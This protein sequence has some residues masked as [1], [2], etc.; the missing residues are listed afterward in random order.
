M[1]HDDLSSTK[2]CNWTS[3]TYTTAEADDG[4]RQYMDNQP[5]VMTE[6]VHSSSTSPLAIPEILTRVGYFLPLWVPDGHGNYD[7]KPRTIV[8]CMLVSKQWYD[9]LVPI[10][11]HTCLSARITATPP[12]VLGRFLP[13]IRILQTNMFFPLVAFQCNR[14]VELSILMRTLPCD[15]HGDGGDDKTRS[16]SLNRYKTLV[17]SNPRLKSLL[18]NGLLFSDKSALD[19][20][21]LAGL[22]RLE[23][24]TLKCWDG[25]GGRLASALGAVARTLT[26]LTLQR[27]D[28]YERG[29]VIAMDHN[30]SSKDT[31][32]DMDAGSADNG[33]G[34]GQ[35]TLAKMT[36]L[37][38]PV[39]R[40]LVLD[41]TG[42][43][44]W[45]VGCCPSLELLNIIDH[46]E[47]LDTNRIA[48]G[49]RET[50]CHQLQILHVSHTLTSREVLPLIWSCPPSSPGLQNLLLNVEGLEADVVS[51]ILVHAPTLK[52]LDLSIQRCYTSCLPRILQL[53][54]G[55]P[56]RLESLSLTIYKNYGNDLVAAL[57]SRTW[58]CRRLKEL[59]LML[60][61]NR[62]Y[63][64]ETLGH[65]DGGD[66]TGLQ[67]LEEEEEDKEEV[68]RDIKALRVMTSTQSAMGWRLETDRQPDEFPQRVGELRKVFKMLARLRLD[69]L[70]TA[71]WDQF[72]Y[73]RAS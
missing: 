60:G 48:Q 63:G 49:I 39:L 50:A 27:V 47:D 46:G 42:G 54:G 37:C 68:E 10:L 45:L 29:V 38:L 32:D 21:D 24:L 51:G 30:E 43:V 52:T 73:R 1:A 22:T 7:D 31:D 28:G 65:G 57:G 61:F 64:R 5:T 13:H 11:W 2:A 26:G 41:T 35:G 3:A 67:A 33:G 16:R 18:W 55:C 71:G 6:R 56:Q 36:T 44:E 72:N 25:S 20:V 4:Q 9:V 70:Q 66:D 62:G 58:G 8:N 12:Q 40:D 19:L 14:L 23:S 34:S 59:Y 17:R 53:L 15:Y 69:E